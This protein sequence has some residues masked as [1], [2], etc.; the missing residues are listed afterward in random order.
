MS[1]PLATDNFSSP[2]SQKPSMLPEFLTNS[3]R[4]GRFDEL[5]AKEIIRSEKWTVSSLTEA[6]LQA[7]LLGHL[8]HLSERTNYN[9]SSMTPSLVFLS[10][11]KII[12]LLEG[13]DALD[14]DIKNVTKSIDSMTFRQLLRDPRMSYPLLRAFLNILEEPS[15]E[16][17]VGSA[18]TLRDV[19]EAVLL[20]EHYIRSRSPSSNTDGK[21]LVT[22]E[23][24]TKIFRRSINESDPTIMIRRKDPPPGGSEVL[25][26]KRPRT[27]RILASDEA[28][29]LTFQRITCGILHGLDWRNVFMAGGLA[30]TTLMH[31]DE[32]KD[33]ERGIRDGDIDLYLY[34]L[35]PEEANAKVEHIYNVWSSN[36]P[37][38]NRQQLVVKNAK[39]ITFLAD[40]P[41]R[42]VQ[43]I[44]KLLPSPT[45][46]LLNIDIDPCAVG[47]DGS[48]V[49]MLPRCARALETGYSTFT[50]DLI[51]GHYLGNRRATRENRLFKY[52]DR[53]FGLRILPCYVQSL[54]N[55]TAW[56]AT[57]A[58]R[59]GSIKA[60]NESQDPQSHFVDHGDYFKYRKS[61]LE[62]GM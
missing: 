58:F 30:L 43:I 16:N 18:S 3:W 48:H 21:Y 53:G 5:H 47:F 55:N 34:D 4:L 37:V 31:V 1:S 13:S 8:N 40:Y 20:N 50:M 10:V 22:L 44:L 32:S 36:L 17:K 11:G 27:V 59:A 26:E 38:S 49:K 60:T 51:W 57:S 15:A 9:L 45:E 28:F 12:Q 6:Y 35:G 14:S 2:E 19:D 54:E 23:D 46:I 62:P 52:A 41:N 42:R 61:S 33:H 56:A 39:T 24:L 25:D 7:Q 29:S